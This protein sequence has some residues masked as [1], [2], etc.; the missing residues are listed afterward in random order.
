MPTSITAASI[1]ISHHLAE[2]SVSVHRR[3]STIGSHSNRR[4]RSPILS[5]MSVAEVVGGEG[6]ANKLLV[7]GWEGTGQPKRSSYDRD[8][9]P[10][11]VNG[12]EWAVDIF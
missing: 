1:L 4:I 10:P 8:G 5:R 6:R 2:S 7:A 11:L 3:S 9:A 12:L